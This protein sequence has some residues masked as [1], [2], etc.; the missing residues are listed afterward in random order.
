MDNLI[1]AISDYISSAVA[2]GLVGGGV[3]LFAG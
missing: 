1:E 3:L 2:I